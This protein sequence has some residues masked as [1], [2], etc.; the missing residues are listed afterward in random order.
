MSVL[1]SSSSYKC[2]HYQGG[3]N[4]LLHAEN[5]PSYPAVKDRGSQT[6]LPKLVCSDQSETVSV[7]VGGL[8]IPVSTVDGILCLLVIDNL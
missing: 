7:V 4:N 8:L 1:F 2:R 5:T 3:H 6:K